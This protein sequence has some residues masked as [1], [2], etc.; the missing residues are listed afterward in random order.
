M[1]QLVGGRQPPRAPAAR[2]ALARITIYSHIVY[3]EG[4][5]ESSRAFFDIFIYEAYYTIARAGLPATRVAKMP[6]IQGCHPWQFFL[7]FIHIYE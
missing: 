3:I 1:P 7:F 5:R 2:Y 4:R 6:I